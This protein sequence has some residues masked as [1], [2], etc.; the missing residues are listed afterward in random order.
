MKKIKQFPYKYGMFNQ[1]LEGMTIN[2]YFPC[3]KVFDLKTQTVII[4]DEKSK[5]SRN[6]ESRM[7][8]IRNSELFKENNIKITNQSFSGFTSSN[9]LICGSIVGKK[10]DFVLEGFDSIE[11]IIKIIPDMRKGDIIPLLS[12]TN[13]SEI[14]MDLM[15]NCMA[16]ISHIENFFEDHV[17]EYFKNQ[18]VISK[19]STRIIL[20]IDYFSSVMNNGHIINGVLLEKH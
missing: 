2:D 5:L 14:K 3:I 19:K 15:A 6:L 8:K 13:P 11:E 7:S 10:S 9:K 4:N 17:F 20:N 18:I 16:M 1:L 12:V